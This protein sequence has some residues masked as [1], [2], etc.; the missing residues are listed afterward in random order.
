MLSV[1]L[2]YGGV[3]ISGAWEPTAKLFHRWSLGVLVAFLLIFLALM[4][5]TLRGRL[6][7]SL[8]AIP[9]SAALGYPAATLAYIV[10]F[11]AFE[12]QRTLNSLTHS[13]LLDVIVV[14]LFLGP[15]SSFAWL[16][17]AVAGAVFFLLG[18]TLQT[19]YLRA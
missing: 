1:I 14:L 9:I 18:R 3:A 6:A 17:G 4:F 12:P 10:Y 15:T 13:Q 8:W 2:A 16:F 7:K 11:S 19:V 5:L